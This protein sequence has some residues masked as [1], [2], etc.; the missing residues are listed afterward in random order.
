[1]SIKN[2]IDFKMKYSVV[3]SICVADGVLECHCQWQVP[4]ERQNSLQYGFQSMSSGE[5]QQDL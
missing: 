3:L 1:M 4:Q 5:E 2:T